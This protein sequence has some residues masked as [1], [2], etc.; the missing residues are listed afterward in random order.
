[1]KALICKIG[2]DLAAP[3]KNLREYASLKLRFHGILRFNKTVKIGPGSSFEGA[4]SIG[5]GSKFTGHMGYGSY[6]MDGCNLTAEIGRFCS[7]GHQVMSTRGTHPYEAPFATTSPMFYSL[8]KQAMETF[9]SEQR[10][11]EIVPPTKIGNDCWIGSKVFF[12][13]GIKV[14]DGAV[15]LSGAVVTKDVPPY[16][17]V[18]GVPARIIKYRYDEQTIAWLLRTRWWDL[19]I[20]W[21][22]SHS[23]LLCDIEKLRAALDENQHNNG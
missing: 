22:R 5:D 17:V 19:P 11:E 18:G 14:G 1:M 2:R 7:I 12:V 20:D 13:G 4:D 16:A 6:M 23:E 15:V 21:L 8:R 9:A 3:F 10:F